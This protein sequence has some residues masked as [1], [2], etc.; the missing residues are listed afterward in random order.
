MSSTF[1]G[2]GTL[3][4]LGNYMAIREDKTYF[5][6][7]GKALKQITSTSALNDIF[8]VAQ[9]GD[10]SEG[11]EVVGGLDDNEFSSGGEEFDDSDSE[12][13][14]KMKEDQDEEEDVAAK[15]DDCPVQEDKEELVDNVIM[16]EARMEDIDAGMVMEDEDLGNLS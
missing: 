2:L 13:E 7:E 6:K 12:Y 8:I 15:N 5:I 10:E 14:Y 11:Y 9:E 1:M 4:E 16:N 3:N